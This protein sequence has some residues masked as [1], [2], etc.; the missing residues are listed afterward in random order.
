MTNSPKIIFALLLLG[1]MAFATACSTS[2]KVLSVEDHPNGEVTLLKTLTTNNMAAGFY[3]TT[4]YNYW[5]CRRSDQGLDCEKTCWN[6]GVSGN[7]PAN[8]PKDAAMC[9]GNTNPQ[10]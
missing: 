9:V 10:Q 8:A 5:E 2:Y 7:L 1:V 3:N 4:Q 6:R